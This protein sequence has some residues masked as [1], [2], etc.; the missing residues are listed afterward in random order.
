MCRSSPLC[1]STLQRHAR[2]PPRAH[3]NIGKEWMVVPA[4]QIKQQEETTKAL[5]D[6]VK[7]HKRE[8]VLIYDAAMKQVVA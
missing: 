6:K 8:R 3:S 7:G 4:E 5:E 2:V 1:P